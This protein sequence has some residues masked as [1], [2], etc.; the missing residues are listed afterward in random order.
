[1]GQRLN[2]KLN[3]H[4]RKT[5]RGRQMQI[6]YLTFF[7]IMPFKFKFF[8][9]LLVI[10]MSFL[11]LSK[12]SFWSAL[13]NWN[14]YGLDLK[15]LMTI[16]RAPFEK[17]VMTIVKDKGFESEKAWMSAWMTTCQF[18]EVLNLIGRKSNDMRFPDQFAK[19]TQFPNNSILR[20]RLLTSLYI[21]LST[22]SLRTLCVILFKSFTNIPR[23]GEIRQI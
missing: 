18:M 20:S 11:F 16:S 19:E 1:M 3:F 14:D 17:V 13:W 7:K 22:A 21:S 23:K 6:V 9:I 12:F 15:I 4:S 10:P 2:A 5:M 8:L